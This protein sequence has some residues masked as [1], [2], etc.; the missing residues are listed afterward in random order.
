MAGSDSQGRPTRPNAVTGE[1]RWWYE[2]SG[3][4]IIDW[5]HNDIAQRVWAMD[6]SGLVAMEAEGDAA[7]HGAQPGIAI[8]RTG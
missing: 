4:K 1:F 6:D 3:G 8:T 5:H 7:V 2:H